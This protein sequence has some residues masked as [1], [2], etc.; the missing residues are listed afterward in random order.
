MTEKGN[1]HPD[2]GGVDQTDP[3]GKPGE[4][5]QTTAG[6]QTEPYHTDF[7]TPF[8]DEGRPHDPFVN[9]FGVVIGDGKY[10]SPQS[11]LNQW[12][13]D[14]DPAVM[15]GDRWVHPYNDIG[16]NTKEN[17]DYF[18]KG[19]PPQGVPFMHPTKDVSYRRD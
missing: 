13:K 11:P 9:E 6:G 8:Q 2:T 15:A 16:F 3:T 1:H 19:I 17:R 12:S 10:N 5:D 14:V 18:E 4:A 7:Q